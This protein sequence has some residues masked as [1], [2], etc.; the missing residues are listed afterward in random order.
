MSQQTLRVVAI[1][2]DD[3]DLMI[4]RRHMK[5]L[6]ELRAE[7]TE[8]RTPDEA[9][10]ALARGAVDLVILDYHLGAED[11]LDLLRDIRAS[12]QMCPVIFLTGQGNEE[13][14]TQFKRAGGNDYLV[15]DELSPVTLRASIE[16]VLAEHAAEQEQLGFEQ[17]L[18]RMAT[19]DRVTGLLNKNAFIELF[20]QELARA[21]RY[22]RPLTL[23]VMDLDGFHRVNEEVGTDGGDQL[24][25]SAAV[26]LRGLLRTTDH[27]CRFGADRFAVALTE[28]GLD[29]AQPVAERVRE[30]VQNTPF[31]GREGKPIALTCTIALKPIDVTNANVDRAII[32][33][34]VAI[35]RAKAEGGNR[36][37]V[38]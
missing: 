25:A 31:E 13:V 4:L 24:L 14:A 6:T 2:D 3:A 12:G 20:V 28:T 27:F 1:D 9:R 29:V 22:E 23:M 16:R 36:V 11:G 17:S 32:D 7:V 35:G 26:V 33:G 5:Q 19:E 34:F 30:Y 37:V 10:T 15:K 18:I 8:A 38:A 21:E